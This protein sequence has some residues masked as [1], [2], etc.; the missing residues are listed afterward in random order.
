VTTPR[1]AATALACWAALLV[2]PS[3]A[4]P[5]PDRAAD[6]AGLARV[7]DG[8]TIL[9][10]DE[11]IRIFG[12]DAAESGQSCRTADGGD[13]PCGRRATARMRALIDGTSVSCWGRDFDGYGRRLATCF[14]ERDGHPLDLG[15][16]LVVEGLAWAFR[17]Y[18]L[19]YA[20]DEDRARAARRGIWIALT[21]TPWDYR[22]RRWTVAAQASPRPD[23]PIKGNISFEG[24]RIYHPPWSPWYT[25]TR[26]REEYG[27][28]WFCTEAE[29]RAAG[30]R[31]ARF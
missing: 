3:Q 2:A 22:A 20:A 28:R 17:G 24:E 5:R 31:A 13:W 10:G 30:W 14:V 26:I 7:E 19:V 1:R 12:V 25:R 18:S 4:T 23:C 15:R 11:E 29:A 9:I 21:E 16:A 27:E 8:D 6:I